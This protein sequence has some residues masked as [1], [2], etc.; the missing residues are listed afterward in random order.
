VPTG[1]DPQNEGAAKTKAS[2]APTE[3]VPQ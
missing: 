3:E 2:N 1:Q